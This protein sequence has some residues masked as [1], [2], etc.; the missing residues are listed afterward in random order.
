MKNRETF[1]KSP[2]RGFSQLSH[3]IKTECRHQNPS[4]AHYLLVGF[5]V[6][7]T[8]VVVFAVVGLIAGVVAKNHQ[9][10]M[11]LMVFYSL[12]NLLLSS[13]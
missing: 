4:E 7:V 6:L 13:R 9:I 12:G 8:P 10:S 11:A 5:V 2:S 3:Y 1:D